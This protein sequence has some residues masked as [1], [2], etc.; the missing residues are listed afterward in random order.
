MGGTAEHEEAS[1]PGPAA[2][3]AHEL[4]SPLASVLAYSELIQC[5]SQDVRVARSAYEIRCAVL[6]AL[7]LIDAYEARRSDYAESVT[8]AVDLPA[9]VEEATTLVRPLAAERDVALEVTC[10]PHAVRCIRRALLQALVNILSNAVKH[11]DRGGRVCLV[12]R[13][14]GHEIRVEV[15]D[16]GPGLTPAQCAQLFRPYER[17]DAARR[18]V[19]GRG[20]GL[21]ISKQLVEEMGGWIAV[22]SRPG[23]G[24]TITI[25]LPSAEVGG[26]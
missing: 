3:L 12:A 19:D 5:D 2:Q 17:L 14:A 20:L 9:A 10:E 16:T 11:N 23:A 8:D 22:S 4:R 13:A 6:Y 1:A 21:W 15:C 25:A 18:G 24:T 7:D 26:G